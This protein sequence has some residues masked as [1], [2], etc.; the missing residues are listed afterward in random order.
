MGEA[1][2]AGEHG[3]KYIYIASTGDDSAKS[4][5][6]R[7]IGWTTE[8]EVSRMSMEEIPR[9]VKSTSSHIAKRSKR[10]RV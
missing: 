7:Q 4:S 9:R 5:R 6:S 8:P 10:M 3:S 2:K 1:A